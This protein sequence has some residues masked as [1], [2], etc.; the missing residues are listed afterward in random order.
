MIHKTIAIAIGVALVVG[1]FMYGATKPLT[2]QVFAAATPCKI[3]L[4][5]NVAD[6]SINGNLKM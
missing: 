5:F 6:T 1:A 4:S 3:T 2:N